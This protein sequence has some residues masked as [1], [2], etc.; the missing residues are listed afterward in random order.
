MKMYGKIRLLILGKV[1]PTT[2]SNVYGS[3]VQRTGW[4]G[5]NASK[6]FFTLGP[7]PNSKILEDLR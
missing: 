6:K 2:T 7:P 4:R 1:A 3:K 5:W